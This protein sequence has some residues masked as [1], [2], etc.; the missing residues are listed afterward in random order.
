MSRAARLSAKATTGS[1]LVSQRAWAEAKRKL[2]EGQIQAQSLGEVALKGVPQ[3]ME[4]FDCG[5]AVQLGSAWEAQQQKPPPV[6]HAPGPATAGSIGSPPNSTMANLLATHTTDMSTHQ[7]PDCIQTSAGGHETLSKPLLTL[8]HSKRLKTLLPS[9]SLN[10]KGSARSLQ[11][12]TSF[13]AMPAS[14]NTRRLFTL[15]IRSVLGKETH[16]NLASLLAGAHH[17]QLGSASQISMTSGVIRKDVNAGHASGPIPQLS[18]LS[19]KTLGSME[20]VTAAA[21][22]AATGSSLRPSISLKKLGNSHSMVLPKARRMSGYGK[23]VAAMESNANDP[24][25]GPGSAGSN[26][27]PNAT[28]I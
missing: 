25:P 26:S 13:G 17:Q 11:A 18:G 21:A 14:M 3:P 20:E 8:E 22:A 1:I 5:R 27:V 24:L 12:S 28:N 6:T 19:M 23:Y 2:P 16:Q 9:S 10:S 15:D 7:I 4:V